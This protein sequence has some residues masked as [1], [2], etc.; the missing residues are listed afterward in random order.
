MMGECIDPSQVGK[1]RPHF[2]KIIQNGVV[3]SGMTRTHL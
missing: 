3:C 1:K 2:E